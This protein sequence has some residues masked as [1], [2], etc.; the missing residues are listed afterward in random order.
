MG[1]R[2]EP[3]FDRVEGG[4][5]GGFEGDMKV[6]CRRGEVNR[7]A[8]VFLNVIVLISDVIRMLT[9]TFRDIISD[10]V[11]IFLCLCLFVCLGGFMC[12]G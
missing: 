12:R 5:E 2:G 7:N 1:A 3:N 10:L 6:G 4:V 9:T 11:V 8:C